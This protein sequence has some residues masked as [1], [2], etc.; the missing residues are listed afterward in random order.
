[1]SAEPGRGLTTAIVGV[2]ARAHIGHHAIEAGARL[3]AAVDPEPAAHERAKKLFGDV[4]VYATVGDLLDAEPA[5]D[6]AIVAS[7]DHTHADISTEL[8]HAGVAVYLEKPIATS[9]EDADR[10]LRAAHDSGAKLYLG[11]N[12]RHMHVVRL[13]RELIC[14]GEIGEVTAIWCRH[15]VGHGGDYYFKDWHADRAKSTSLLLQKGAH[16]IDV[17]HWLAGGVTREVVAMGELRVYGRVASRRDNSDRTMRDWFSLDNWPP[18]AQTELNPVVDV[19]D[20]SMVLM[21][22]DNGVLASYHQCHYTPDYWRNYTVIG[23][24]GRIENF[25]DTQGGEVVLYRRRTD[26]PAE[27][28]ARYPIIGDE[29][30]HGDADV[31]AMREFLALVS[32]GD[33]TDTNPVQA[34][35]A[36]AAGVAATASLRSG[37]TPRTIRPADPDLVAYF[38]ANQRRTEPL[39]PLSRA[40]VAEPV[41]HTGEGEVL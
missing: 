30:G 25:G 9:T 40:A 5:L 29:D 19:E 11:H 3:I 22:M 8:L 13:M 18:G 20:V 7:P 33:P 41:R 28:D 24:E 6:T 2:G 32:S 16:D 14:G 26:Y 35:D 23:T 1:M 12:M 17:M 15:F 34:R 4:P 39:E 37:S 38:A 27:P 36:V 21:R 10:V 31:L